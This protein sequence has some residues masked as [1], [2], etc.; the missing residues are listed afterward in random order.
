[1]QQICDENDRLLR[2]INDIQLWVV[3]IAVRGRVMEG[4]HD[5]A[6]HLGIEK[7]LSNLQK[8]YWFPRILTD[9]K[10]YVNSY[11]ECRQRKQRR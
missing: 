2:K 5:N 7:T 1:M 10:S 9:I 4:K 6:G 3:S 11:I 8:H